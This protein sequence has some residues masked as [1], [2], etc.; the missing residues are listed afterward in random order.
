MLPNL[1]VIALNKKPATVVSLLVLICTVTALRAAA[2]GRISRQ[3]RILLMATNTSCRLLVFYNLLFDDIFDFGIAVFVIVEL[4]L[5]ATELRWLARS[6][7]RL[8]A[9]IFRYE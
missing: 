8:F 4:P 7:T 3:A 6:G 1:A 9:R 5:A 2:D